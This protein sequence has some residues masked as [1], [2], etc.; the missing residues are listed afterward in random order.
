MCSL[1]PENRLKHQ[2]WHFGWIAWRQALTNHEIMRRLIGG[3]RLEYLAFHIRK[4]LCK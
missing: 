3:V 4:W 1:E 2:S